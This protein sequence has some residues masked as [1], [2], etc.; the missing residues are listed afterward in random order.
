VL[1][2][3]RCT[4]HWALEKA[5]AKRCCDFPIVGSQWESALVWKDIVAEP[6]EREMTKPLLFR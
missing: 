5:D 2:V 1:L 6:R 4:S 3:R